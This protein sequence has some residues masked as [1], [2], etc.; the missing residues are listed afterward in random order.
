[1]YKID[2][3]AKFCSEC[4][5]K[6]HEL[7]VGDII[8]CGTWNGKPIDWVVLDVQERKQRALVMSVQGLFRGKYHEKYEEITWEICTLREYLNGDFFKKAFSDDADRKKV[9]VVKNHKKRECVKFTL[10]FL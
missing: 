3:K 8:Q 4:G 7:K 5:A 10:P 9:H 2:E 1:M 6:Q